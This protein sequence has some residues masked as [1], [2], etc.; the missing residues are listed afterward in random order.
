MARAILLDTIGVADVMNIKNIDEPSCSDDEVVI[1]QKAVEVNYMDI[2][3]RNGTYQFPSGPRIPGTSAIGTITKVGRN[4]SGFAVGE[5]VGYCLALSGAYVTSRSIHKDLIFKIPSTVNDLTAAAV[6]TKGMAAH[7]LALR[8][9]IIRKEITIL[10]HNVTGGVAHM[11]AQYARI[12]GATIIGTID[13][14]SKRSFA[15]QLGC[16]YVINHASENLLAK[17]S[18]Y[19]SKNG[20]NAVYDSIGGPMLDDNLTMLATFGILI[21]YGETG[22]FLPKI[23]T[24][25]LLAKSLFFTRPSIYHYKRNRMEMILTADDIFRR[26]AA[27]ELKV[28]IDSSFPLEEANNA[29]KRMESSESMGSIVLTV[30]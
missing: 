3:Y 4:V 28:H 25:R 5:R 17:V 12:C 26:I 19:T 20:V 7:M 30:T 23:D 2:L 13:H 29:H 22:G 1:S 6:L 15:K 11:L 16:D 9:F 24:N 14:E 18:E 27:G 10:I 8:T 21:S